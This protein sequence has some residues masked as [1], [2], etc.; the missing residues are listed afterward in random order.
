MLQHGILR[1]FRH[2]SLG[3]DD[4]ILCAV[5]YIGAAYTLGLSDDSPVELK[6][7]HAALDGPCHDA[8]ILEMGHRDEASGEERDVQ[9]VQD[10]HAA[11]PAF[12]GGLEAYCTFGDCINA[13]PVS[14]VHLD[15]LI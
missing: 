9:Y 3:G 8:P 11:H 13:R 15:G 14:D 2:R 5:Q 1:R 7:H 10:L 12:N 4:A 6:K